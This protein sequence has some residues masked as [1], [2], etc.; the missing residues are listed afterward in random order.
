MYYQLFY[1]ITLVGSPK[2]G[3]G[4]ALDYGA[5]TTDEIYHVVATDSTTGCSATM[6]GTVEIVT[7]AL[8]LVHNVTG[9]GS[10]CATGSGVHIGLDGYNTGISYQLHNG[11]VPVGSS[12]LGSVGPVDFG[13]MTDTGAYYAVAT[14]IVT[15]CSSNM[16]GSANVVVN[17]MVTPTVSLSTGMG[18]TI[19]SGHYVTITSTAT[20]TGTSPLYAWTV[21]GASVSAGGVY[22][23]IPSEGD[24]VVVRLTSST[25]CASPATVYGSLSLTVLASGAPT[26]HITSSSGSAVCSGT[27][28]NFNSFITNGG[29]FPALIWLVNNVPA[30]SG[31]SYS[32][33]PV[34]HDAITALL[35]SDY[36]CRVGDS[37]TSNSISM[38]V[39]NPT[40]PVVTITP[41]PVAPVAY[42]QTVT[43]SATASNAGPSPT[44]QWLVNGMPVPGATFPTY[45]SNS[46][47]NGDSVTCLVFS[48]GGCPGIEGNKSVTI[49]VAGTGVQQIVSSGSDV[50][51]VP[52]PNKGIFSLKGSLGTS[53]DRDATITITN[54]LGQVVYSSSF[55][56]R[57]GKVDE[58]VALNI[59]V[60][61]GM[62]LLNLRSGDQNNVFHFVLEQ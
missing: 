50:R 30:G 46:F 5:F 47:F 35:I 1:G 12:A 7:D 2:A 33:N 3:T 51:L 27:T 14:N 4:L 40:P 57:D 26:A 24:H 15:G 18:D 10:Y 60:A 48:S 56:V 49:H 37:A 6:P 23:Y 42:G 25:P 41:N 54:M 9:G 17:P 61:N 58:Q 59:S 38:E 22:S 13:L 19:C 16:A 36:F 53:G 31:A 29:P 20:N 8:P 55:V 45:S 32:Y 62:Y 44:Y 43:L 39:D 28:V 11:W 52:N 21:N 34:N